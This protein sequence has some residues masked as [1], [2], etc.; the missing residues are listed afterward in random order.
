MLTPTGT[1]IRVAIM[2]VKTVPERS[3]RIPKCF[4]S[5]SGVHCVSVMNSQKETSAKNFMVSTE[6]TRIIPT[7]VRTE[8]KLHRIMS[9]SMNFSD[10]I[11]VFAIFFNQHLLLIIHKGWLLQ[12]IVRQR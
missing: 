2:V 3:G 10:L 8:I 4:S 7:V 1:A 6:S 12:W 5:N 11:D 9:S